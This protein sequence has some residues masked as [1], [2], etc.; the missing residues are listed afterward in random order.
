MTDYSNN[1]TKAN[2]LRRVEF[3]L[4]CEKIK[5]KGNSKQIAMV[6]GKPRLFSRKA[7]KKAE[8]YLRN[9]LLPYAPH[10]PFEGPVIRNIGFVMAIPKSYP[11]WKRAAAIDGSLKHTKRPDA[12][13]LL[14][15]I[16][17]VLEFTGFVHD[18]SQFFDGRIWREYGLVTGYK[19]H[20]EEV[21][22]AGKPS[23]APS[24]PDRKKAKW[25]FE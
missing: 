18:D 10:R 20:L 1:M 21:K 24:H 13:N 5:Q 11:K 3:F 4:P 12:G 9:I 15:L 19:I 8:E 17:D 16:E 2:G 7:D 14:K 25:L 22:Q 6:G 23:K